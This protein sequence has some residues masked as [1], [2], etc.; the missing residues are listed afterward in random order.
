MADMMDKTIN[1]IITA[2]VAVVLVASAFI[3]TVIP[4]INGLSDKFPEAAGYV[5]LLEVV[6]TMTIIGIVIGVIKMYTSKD[7]DDYV[8]EED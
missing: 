3:P 5:T 8:Y 7:D 2:F 4:M 1:S 6:V